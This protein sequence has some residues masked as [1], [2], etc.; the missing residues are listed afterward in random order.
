MASK[1]SA[2]AQQKLDA[3]TEARRKWDRVHSLIELAATQKTGQDMYLQ[4]IRRT[5]QDV[6]RVFLNNGLGPLADGA[7]EMALLSRRGGTI[8]SKI[9]A[10]REQVGV[11]RGGI[12]RAEKAVI[13]EEK[14]VPGS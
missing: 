3:L 1:L 11:V 5:A 14:E 2:Q 9:R 12:E 7:N 4:Q 8:Q 6:G 10:M 13:D